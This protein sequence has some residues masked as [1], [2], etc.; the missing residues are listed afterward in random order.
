[1][2]R[3]E[4]LTYEA[5]EAG[6]VLVRVRT[7]GA[8]YPDAM[9][10]AGAFPLLGAPPFGLGEEVAGEVVAVASGSKF[11]VGDPIM[12]ITAF[13]EGW[14]GY[15][16][17]AYVLEQS[18]VRVPE[19]LTEEQAGGFPIAY[20]TAYAGLIERPRLQAGETLVV[21]GGAGS[22]GVAAIQLGKACGARVIAVAGSDEK[23]AFASSAG[24]DDVV[25]HRSADLAKE[26]L[27]L[28]DGRG[29]D[30]IYDVVGGETANTAVRALARDGRIAIVGY[31]SGTLVT[32]DP[33]DMLMRNYSAVGVLGV[34]S[35]EADAIAWSRLVELVEAGKLATPVGHV[36]SFDKVPAMVARQT[37]PLPGKMVVRVA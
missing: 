33:A 7:A 30:L 35:P 2:L 37:A 12:G 31:A 14:G 17:Y 36:W 8:G 25:S 28:T 16:E 20:R 6:R 3:R 4:R 34:T 11:A 1:V 9:M 27:A 18:A 23:L 15:A 26:L 5:P 24:A 32:L 29:V 10:A 21:L 19:A 13:L 22:S